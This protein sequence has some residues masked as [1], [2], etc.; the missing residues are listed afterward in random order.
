MNFLK[1]LILSISIITVSASAGMW[2]TISGLSFKEIKPEAKFTIDTAGQNPR[3][4][5]FTVQGSKPTMQCVII[6]TE[7]EYKAPVLQCWKKN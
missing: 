3:A 7:G 6:F 5:T 4:Y 1:K 2:T